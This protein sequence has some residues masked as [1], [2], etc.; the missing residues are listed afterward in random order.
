MFCHGCRR[1]K[2]ERVD[3]VELLHARCRIHVGHCIHA[4][5]PPYVRFLSRGFWNNDVELI[6]MSTINSLE[7]RGSS[8]PCDQETNEMALFLLG[9]RNAALCSDATFDGGAERLGLNDSGRGCFGV[10][11]AGDPPAVGIVLFGDGGMGDPPN[12]TDIRDGANSKQSYALPATSFA[13]S[14]SGEYISVS[15][16]SVTDGSVRFGGINCGALRHHTLTSI[17]STC[18]AGVALNNEGERP[19][20]WPRG[21]LRIGASLAG[22]SANEEFVFFGGDMSS[23][24]PVGTRIGDGATSAWPDESLA[25]SNAT[26]SSR[27]GT[28]IARDPV[29][30]ELVFFGGDT[31]SD[32][33]VGTRIGD[34]APSTWPDESLAT[35]NATPSSRRGTS[36]ARDPVSEELVFFGGDTSSD[37]SVGPRVWDSAPWSEVV[38]VNVSRFVGP[39]R[40]VPSDLEDVP[41]GDDRTFGEPAQVGG[42]FIISHFPFDG[43]RIYAA[44]T[45]AFSGAPNIVSSG[46]PA[47]FDGVAFP[48]ADVAPL[49][50]VFPDVVGAAVP[51]PRT[52]TASMA[53]SIAGTLTA[54]LANPVTV[55]VRSASYPTITVATATDAFTILAGDFGPR[56]TGAIPFDNVLS[57]TNLEGHSST[58]ADQV[59]DF[60]PGSNYS[61][62]LCSKTAGLTAPS[63]HRHGGI[64]VDHL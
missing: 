55:T 56:F 48:T 45:N 22:D 31:S 32:L 43:V 52:G 13:A 29:G 26:P 47:S 40:P 62:V 8:S 46:L 42:A 20:S 14:S 39:L 9:I 37:L 60:T 59:G 36:I 18:T 2:G 17:G 7:R 15:D 27:R 11:L 44:S 63:G 6:V 41:A 4:G 30:E 51:S 35:S 49:A 24:L 16:D 5:R 23:D 50:S 38:D 3:R 1:C 25:T 33:S 34:G 21:L 28:S 10:A 64:R 58:G 61:G 57:A 19:T 54:G 12:G 53:R